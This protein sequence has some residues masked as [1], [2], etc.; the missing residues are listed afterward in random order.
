MPKCVGRYLPHK[1]ILLIVPWTHAFNPPLQKTFGTMSYDFPIVTVEELTA[2]AD[3]LSSL[4]KTT[5][6]CQL[7][8]PYTRRFVENIS[9]NARRVAL[10]ETAESYAHD[11][12]YHAVL[13]FLDY[14][15]DAG[16]A[17]VKIMSMPRC[18]AALSSAYA[19]LS[20][21]GIVRVL[22][23][24]LPSEEDAAAFLKDYH[25]PLDSNDPSGVDHTESRVCDGR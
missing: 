12:E 14:M 9:D 11:D 20:L 8:G 2:L 25:V 17:D 4:L 5:G 23:W 21:H 22:A 3:L 7:P 6:D 10:S 15:P 19:R 24:L 16:V 13:I 18:R 1:L